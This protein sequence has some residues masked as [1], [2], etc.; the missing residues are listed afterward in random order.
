MTTLTSI[1]K[2]ALEGVSLGL[3]V[4][5]AV[6]VVLA[7]IYRTLGSSLI[8]YDEIASVLLMVNVLWLRI[9]RIEAR[10]LGLY[11]NSAIGV[12]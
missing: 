6:I 3:L 5:L 4:T 2:R 9:G 7:V 8:W 1:F 11:G 12:A 10:T